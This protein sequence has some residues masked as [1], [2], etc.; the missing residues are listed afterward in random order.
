MAPSLWKDDYLLVSKETSAIK[1]GNVVL[2]KVNKKMDL[3]YY[4]ETKEHFFLYPSNPNT[5]PVVVFKNKSGDFS[6]LGK[7]TAFLRKTS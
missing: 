5:M 4:T 1:D 7:I 2:F 6:V 3:M